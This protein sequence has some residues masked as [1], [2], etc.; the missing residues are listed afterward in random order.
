MVVDGVN[1]TQ[2]TFVGQVRSVNPQTTNITYRIDDGTGI[3]DVKRWLDADKID[4]DALNRLLVPDTYVRVWGRLLTFN[5]KKHVGAHCMR[6]VEDFNEVN[7]HMLEAT[8]VHLSLTRAGQVKN[9]GGGDGDGMFVDGGY[10]AGAGSGA[11]TGGY[12]SVVSSKL[13]GCS[14]N[15][16]KVFNFLANFPA[17]GNDGVHANLA[18]SSIGM[19]MR[20]V[21]GAGEELLQN[22]LIYVTLDDETW[23]VLDC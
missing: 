8:Y 18:A 17:A 1:I 15:A 7:Y 14:S 13:S 5:G 6:V 11:D 9:E 16:H 23:A 10:G 12:G 2:V 20:D 4:D 19:P 22:G 3:I 21:L